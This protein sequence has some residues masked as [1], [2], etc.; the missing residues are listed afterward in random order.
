M[1]L[2]PRKRAGVRPICKRSWKHSLRART[3]ARTKAK[4][5]FQRRSCASQSRFDSASRRNA[6]KS[7]HQPFVKTERL[8]F[9]SQLAQRIKTLDRSRAGIADQVIESFFAGD[10][11]EMRD[12]AW[13]PDPH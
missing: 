9:A 13:K 12:A 6:R 11:D 4:R 10:D 7:G 1:R 3:R 5:R 8:D 2:R